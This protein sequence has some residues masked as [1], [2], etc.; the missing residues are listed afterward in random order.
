MRS[1]S[2]AARD[3][4]W[5]RWLVLAAHACVER[6]PGPRNR[7]AT[8]VCFTER[9]WDEA[10]ACAKILDQLDD[11]L[12]QDGR[13][14]A[15]ATLRVA[16]PG[17]ASERVGSHFWPVKVRRMRPARCSTAPAEPAPA[18]MQPNEVIDYPRSA[19]ANRAGSFVTCASRSAPVSRA[20]RV[21]IDADSHAT[22]LYGPPSHAS[23]PIRGDPAR[24]CLAL[25]SAST[26]RCA[27]ASAA[28][29]ICVRYWILSLIGSRA[30]A[31]LRPAS[32]ASA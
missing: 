20:V 25:V 19:E 4:V 9:G 27:L 32:L 13:G 1:Q 15:G 6:R 26:H 29:R 3:L 17:G 5:R 11:E 22:T 2:P 7:R 31:V 8:L 30:H 28:C 21:W 24:S 12:V 16:A 18:T 10:D 23:A 14:T